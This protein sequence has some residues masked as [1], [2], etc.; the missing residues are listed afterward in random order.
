MNVTLSLDD[1][2]VQE[3]NRIA[4]RRETTLDVVVGEYLQPLAETEALARQQRHLEGLKKSFEM[5]QFEVGPRTWTRDD[6]H[7]RD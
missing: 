7:E 6:L 3:L 2:L 4:E 5:F 1:R